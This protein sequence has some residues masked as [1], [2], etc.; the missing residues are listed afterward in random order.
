[1]TEVPHVVAVL[2]AGYKLHERVLRPA[3]VKAGPKPAT[4][5]PASEVAPAAPESTPAPGNS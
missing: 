4:A 1:M 3:L 2:Q 5:E